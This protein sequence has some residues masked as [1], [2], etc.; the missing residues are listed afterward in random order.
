M[1]AFHRSGLSRL[2]AKVLVPQCLELEV[3]FV[4]GVYYDSSSLVSQRIASCE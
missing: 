3:Q 4:G 2:V 1:S